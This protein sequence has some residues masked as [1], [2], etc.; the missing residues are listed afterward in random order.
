MQFYK[1]TFSYE[2]LHYLVNI[3]HKTI[4]FQFCAQNASLYKFIYSKDSSHIGN[5]GMN[6]RFQN[7]EKN[8]FSKLFLILQ[9]SQRLPPG[10]CYSMVEHEDTDLKITEQ[11]AV[12][13]T[14]KQIQMISLD[15][16]RQVKL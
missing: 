10:F 3:I 11:V 6:F 7:L 13:T 4:K 14:F 16:L 2:S 12:V 5:T 9:I 1:N 15:N 8:Y